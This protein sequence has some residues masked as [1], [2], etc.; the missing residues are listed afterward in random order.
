MD[1]VLEFTIVTSTGSHLTVNAY[2]HPDLFWALRGGGGGTYGIL[3][4]V[5]YNTHPSEPVVFVALEA[6]N[7]TSPNITQSILSEFIRF[8]P[9]L[10]DLGWGGYSY[11]TPVSFSFLGVAPNT[12]WADT[13]VIK[14]L[15]DFVDNATFGNALETTIPFDSFYTLYSTILN[16]SAAVGNLVAQNIEIVTRLLPIDLV[17]NGYEKIA[18]V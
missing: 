6:P 5:T 13:N 12:S 15:F 8:H 14:P 3:T 10:T 16:P 2:S 7:I 1:N 18:E 9:T 17:E 11:I 4:S